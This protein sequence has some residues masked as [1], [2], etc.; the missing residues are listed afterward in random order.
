MEIIAIIAVGLLAYLFGTGK[1]SA[2]V[3]GL[4][5]SSTATTGTAPPVSTPNIPVVVN[6]SL[7]SGFATTQAEIGAITPATQ[8]ASALTN[9]GGLLSNIASSGISSAIPIVG[10]AF[11]AIA[12]VLLAASKK[13]AQEATNENQA[14]DAAVP[15]WDSAIQQVV[16]LFNNGSITQAQVG[17]L[18]GT[19]RTMKYFSVPVGQCWQ[20]YW[21]EVGPQV[22]PGRNGCQSGTVTQPGDSPTLPEGQSFCTGDY[23]AGCCVAYGC[24]DDSMGNP[25]IGLVAATKGCIC[26]FQALKLAVASPGTPFVATVLPI[27]SSKYSTFTRG[28]YTVTVCAPSAT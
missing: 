18:L 7:N 22:Q 25:N 8:V 23:G 14:V 3:A 1:L 16:Q 27:Y 5:G 4:P 21:T 12:S 6:Q 15:A 10:A 26:L 17:Q 24:F 28:Q 11:S 13:R 2:G 9:S 20:N 19:P